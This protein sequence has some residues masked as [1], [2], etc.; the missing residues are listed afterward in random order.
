VAL[1]AVMMIA[2]VQATSKEETIAAMMT[3][4][5][6]EIPAQVASEALEVNLAA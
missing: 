2:T 4:T 3:A 6:P 1:A 5:D